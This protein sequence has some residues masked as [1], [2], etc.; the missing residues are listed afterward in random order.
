MG[1]GINYNGVD[2]GVTV[3]RGPLPVFG[4]ITT[5]ATEI[6]NGDGGIAPMSNY[7]PRTIT[8]SVLVQSTTFAGLQASLDTLASR[9]GNRTDA[10]L[11]LGLWPDRYWTARVSG[12]SAPEI[13]NKSTAT[14]TIQWL[15]LDPFAYAVTASRLTGNLTVPTGQTVSVTAAGSVRTYPVIQIVTSSAVSSWAIKHDATE[16]R[17]AYAGTSIGAGAT[18][19]VE[20]RP[21][22]SLVSVMAAGSDSFASAMAGMNGRFPYLDVGENNLVFSGLQG[23]YQIDWSNAYL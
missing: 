23:T 6:T 19:R 8:A 17:L 16:Y 20:C 1:Y 18:I 22:V 7:G 21:D 12:V 14:L 2:L 4:P 15:A 11:I 5:N 13:A 9:L 3:L 10:P